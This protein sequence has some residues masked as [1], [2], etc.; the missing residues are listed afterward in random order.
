MIPRQLYPCMWAEDT[1]GLFQCC[2]VP[3]EWHASCPAQDGHMSIGIL[4]LAAGILDILCGSGCL[5]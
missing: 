3:C 5:A 1:W 4:V 2:T